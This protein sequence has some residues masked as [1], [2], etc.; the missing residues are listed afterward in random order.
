MTK[1]ILIKNVKIGGGNK[2]AVQSMTNT[3]T[4]DIDK[5]VKQIL[6]LEKAGCDIVRVAVPEIKDAKSVKEIIK[7]INIPL[8]CDIHFDYKLALMCIE[9]GAHKIRF[10]PGN[11]GSKENIQRLVLLAK[12]R[13]VPIRIGVNSGSIEKEFLNKNLSAHAA[14][15]ESALKHVRILEDLNFDKIVL[16]VKSSSVIDTVKAY[17]ELH[18]K[19]NYPLHLG[20]TESGFDLTGTVKSSIG[21]GSLLLDGIGDTIRVSLTD[22]PVNEVIVGKEIL[23]ALKKDTDYCEIISCPTCS[24]CEIDLQKISRKVK[25]ITNDIKRPLKIAV[26]GCAVNGLGEA[27]DCDLG[28]AG[29]KEKSVIF[30]GGKVLK[31]VNSEILLDEFIIELKKVLKEKEN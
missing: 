31:T 13:N 30:K 6:D 25:D 23:R 8:C 11:I 17:R 28:I 20:I 21:I 2:I 9:N 12:E 10:N 18:S 22:N 24:R 4:H 26:M 7:Q 3:K 1:E 29:A 19:C 27:K 14:L 16:S 15:F 5:T